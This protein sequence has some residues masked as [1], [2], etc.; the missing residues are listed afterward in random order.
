MS[1]YQFKGRKLTLEELQSELRK[2]SDV[3]L[4]KFTEAIERRKEKG[5]LDILHEASAEWKR[6]HG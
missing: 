3:E 1:F 6:R 5:D 4:L 2:M